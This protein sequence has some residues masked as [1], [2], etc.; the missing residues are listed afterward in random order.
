MSDAES[1]ILSAA[2]VSISAGFLAGDALS[3]G[4]P[5][6]GI[7]SAYNATTG[8]LTLSGAASLAA[9][10]RNSSPSPTP[11]SARHDF[12]P[13]DHSGPSTTAINASAPVTSSHV[14]VSV[15]P[16]LLLI[17]VAN[18]GPD[19]NII[20]Q[21]T[22]GQL[23]LWQ[24]NG[25]T[26]STSGLLGPN[27]GPSWSEMGTGAFFSG[28]TSDILWQNT[29]GQISIWETDGNKLIGGGPKS[30]P[31]RDQAE[32]IGAGDFNDDGHS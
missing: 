5:Q 23:A 2:T 18:P 12:E 10:R 1:V 26:I 28:D 13:H 3:V 17:P 15:A 20:L 32:A 9:Y 16:P 27:P 24:V 21:N 7:A 29:S 4:S 6:T 19:L 11:L 31:I 8:V 30:A 25:V 22:G 14:S